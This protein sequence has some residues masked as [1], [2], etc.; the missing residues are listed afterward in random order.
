MGSFSSVVPIRLSAASAA[1]DPHPRVYCHAGCLSVW[2]TRKI[3]TTLYT[4]YIYIRHDIEIYINSGHPPLGWGGESKMKSFS[5]A[6]QGYYPSCEIVRQLPSPRT[7]TEEKNR[8]LTLPNLWS[9]IV[10]ATI[11][12]C[13]HHFRRLFRRSLTMYTSIYYEIIV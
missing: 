7:L 8:K 13:H 2:S 1:P 12:S 6:F 5:S 10:Y 3:W 4:M 11:K 9:F